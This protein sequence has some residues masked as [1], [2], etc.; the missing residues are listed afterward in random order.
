MNFQT[1]IINNN[2]SV[3]PKIMEVYLKI[4]KFYSEQLCRRKFFP[5]SIVQG[6]KMAKI[7]DVITKGDDVTSSSTSSQH[8]IQ[9]FFLI[10]LAQI[11]FPL[12]QES[13]HV[14]SFENGRRIGVKQS[15][16]WRYSG[17]VSFVGFPQFL[18]HKTFRLVHQ[19]SGQLIIVII[20]FFSN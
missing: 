17:K 9:L 7:D 8:V 19:I 6:L 3:H 1:S 4:Q 15:I 20:Y 12:S 10:F 18:Y 2:F 5:N 11:C 14:F 16:F 13:N